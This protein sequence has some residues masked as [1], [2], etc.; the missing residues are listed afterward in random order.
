MRRA[1]VAALVALLG[2][3]GFGRHETAPE[4]PPLTTVSHVDLDRYLGLWY[5]IARYPNSFQRG[6]LASTA[7]CTQPVRMAG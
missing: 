7:M 4:M 3:C 6:C 2:S 5:E 1:A